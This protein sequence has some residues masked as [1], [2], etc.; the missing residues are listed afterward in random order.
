M[1]NIFSSDINIAFAAWYNRMKMVFLGQG[2]EQNFTKLVSLIVETWSI[3]DPSWQKRKK[4]KKMYIF[5]IA[6]QFTEIQVP[7][8]HLKNGFSQI[9]I[10]L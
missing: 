8:S 10:L 3:F 4:E 5:T 1:L 7:K 6:L 2:I 9:F